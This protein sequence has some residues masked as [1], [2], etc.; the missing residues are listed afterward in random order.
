MAE[1]LERA[2]HGDRTVPNIVSR[3]IAQRARIHHC[4]SADYMSTIAASG[5]IKKSA[6]DATGSVALAVAQC[7]D[8]T[9]YAAP[10]W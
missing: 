2:R 4:P 8:D 5:L 10:F 1:M 7:R 3:Q 6:E 9:Q